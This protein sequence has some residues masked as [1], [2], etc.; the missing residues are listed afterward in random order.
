MWEKWKRLRKPGY[1]VLLFSLFFLGF[2]L[3]G[4]VLPSFLFAGTP[5]V[6]SGHVEDTI[7]IPPVEGQPNEV[8]LCA[9]RAVTVKSVQYK[10]KN[11]NWVDVPNYDVTP[12]QGNQDLWIEIYSPTLPV[13]TEIRVKYEYQGTPP[14]TV[15]LVC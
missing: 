3:R 8:L 13:G 2:F 9:S 5:P 14:P 12:N 11:G 15:S 1:G 4:L 6:G 10:D 7:S